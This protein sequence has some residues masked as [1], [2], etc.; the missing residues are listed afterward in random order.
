MVQAFINK[1]LQPETELAY[2]Q[3]ISR[4]LVEIARLEKTIGQI[5]N[6]CRHVFFETSSSNIRTCVKC[7]YTE[8]VYCKFPE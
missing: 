4:L 8:F 5:Q 3:Y 6:K 7:S 2:Q 1:G